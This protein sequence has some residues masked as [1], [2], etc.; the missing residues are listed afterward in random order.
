MMTLAKYAISAIVLAGILILVWRYRKRG[1]AEPEKPSYYALEVQPS[2]TETRQEPV[3]SELSDTDQARLET[4]RQMILRA[5]SERYG[6]SE[7]RKDKTDLALLQ[8]LLDDEVFAPS[9]TIELQS[10][11]VVLGDVLSSELGLQWVIIMDEYGRDPTLLI[12]G[13]KISFNVLTMISKRVER[14][15]EVNVDR[16]YEVVEAENKRF[17]Q[18]LDAQDAR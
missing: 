1:T 2:E 11:G 9:Q 5:L 10:M 14:G 16:L 15:D 17:R 6:I 12:P 7:L 18:Q 13:S 4:Q 8:K 3:F